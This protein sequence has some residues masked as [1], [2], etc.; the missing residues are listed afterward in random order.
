MENYFEA[1]KETLNEHSMDVALFIAGSLGALMSDKGREVKLSK[2]QRFVSMSFGGITA[3]YS[4]YL[5][6]EAFKLFWDIDL[7]HTASAGI[8]FYAGHIGV[9][10]ITSLM[11]KYSERK[12]K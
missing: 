12:K 10:G 11:V 5:V 3:I 7:S 4:T 6:V 1:F 2:K 9:S 8:G